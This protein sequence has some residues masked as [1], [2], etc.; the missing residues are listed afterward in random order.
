MGWGRDARP[1]LRLANAQRAAAWIFR[2]PF[3]IP[4]SPLAFPS[5]ACCPSE[6]T[7]LSLRRRCGFCLL[8]GFLAASPLGAFASDAVFP[9]G[10]ALLLD[11]PPLPGSKR[12]PMIEIEEDGTASIY[13]WCAAVRG[14]ANVGDDTIS[15]TPTTPMPSQ[16]TPD[17]ISRDAALLVQLSQMTGW[18]READEIDLLGAT[19]LRF[20]L[21]T[22]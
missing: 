4:R 1:H 10:R 22:N 16:C 21:M 13:L 19:T 14:S 6:T 12:V 18:R 5:T 7:M 17:Q 8:L 2:P 20:R 15:I 11:V 3:A 9:F